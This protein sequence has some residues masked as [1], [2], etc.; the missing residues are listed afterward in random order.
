MTN[1]HIGAPVVEYAVS[2]LTDHQKQLGKKK[3][4]AFDIFEVLSA[5]TN[6]KGPIVICH[7]RDA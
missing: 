1:N 4:T 3:F 6:E 5:G 2:F 7:I